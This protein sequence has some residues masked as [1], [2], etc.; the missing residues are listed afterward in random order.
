[1]QRGL[2]TSQERVFVTAYKDQK[3][4]VECRVTIDSHLQLRYNNIRVCTGNIPGY[5]CYEDTPYEKQ[6][7]G[8]DRNTRSG[9]F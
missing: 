3:D 4:P 8:K 1:M 6:I 2:F 9:K 5:F 7:T